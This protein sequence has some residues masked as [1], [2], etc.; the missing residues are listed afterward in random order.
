MFRKSIVAALAIS[1]V[2]LSGCG[3]NGPKYQNVRSFS[4]GLAP[5]QTTNGKWGY[6]NEKQYIVIHPRFDDAKE[7]QNGRA[8]AKLNGKWGFIN[9]RGEWL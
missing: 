2:T 7:F 9:K 3:P 8:A 1:L 5:V 6:I 4:E